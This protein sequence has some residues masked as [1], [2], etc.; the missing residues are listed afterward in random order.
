VR[1]RRA[2][3]RLA[4]AIVAD[5]NARSVDHAA[6]S[7]ETA[8]RAYR[9]GELDGEGLAAEVARQTMALTSIGQALHTGAA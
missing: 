7:L 3:D 1:E 6:A 9:S 2:G 8:M 5:A 4:A